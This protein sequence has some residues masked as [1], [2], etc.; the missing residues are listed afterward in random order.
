MNKNKIPKSLLTFARILRPFGNLATL[1]KS[2]L[3]LPNFIL[4]YY[5]YANSAGCAPPLKDLYPIL[6]E[7]SASA[8]VASGHY[9]HQDLW[10]ARKV[11]ELMPECHIDVGSRIDGF[12]AHVAAFTNIEYVDV[13]P[14]EVNAH[15]SILYKQ[16]SVLKLP[17]DNL[18]VISLSCLHVLEHIGLG[19]YGDPINPN[20]IAEGLHELQRV[21]AVG[22]ALL[23]G[24]PIGRSR[25]CFNAHRVLSPSFIPET[26]TELHLVDFSYVDDSG[27]LYRNAKLEDAQGSEYAC[28]LYYFKRQ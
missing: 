5:E 9:F 22:G 20:G 15:S 28:G 19:R 24:L 13:R 27:D 18:T 11:Y 21:L 4:D 25:V 1:P 26:L 6:H 3:S 23:I 12:V 17:Y 10:A 8:G 14:L 7:K 16:G 2:L